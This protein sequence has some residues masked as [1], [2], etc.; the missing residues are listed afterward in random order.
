VRTQLAP[1]PSGPTGKDATPVQASSGNVAAAPATATLAAG[2]ANVL[3]YL[4]VFEFTGAGAT[5]A[6][7]VALTITGVIGGTMTYN[8]AVPAGATIGIPPLVVEFN[9]PLQAAALNTPIVVSVPSL[10]AGNTNSAVVA[11]GY[12]VPYSS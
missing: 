9:P 7:V 4:S 6:S 3:T 12:Q 10:G 8:I 2:G 1:Y 5:A 11:H